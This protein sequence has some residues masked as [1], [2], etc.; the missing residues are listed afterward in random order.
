M[1][2]SPMRGTVWL[3]TDVGKSQPEKSVFS[4]KLASLAQLLSF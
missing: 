1:L 3:S 4:A 2:L